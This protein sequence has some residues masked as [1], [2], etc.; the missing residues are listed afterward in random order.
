MSA[1]KDLMDAIKLHRQA[2]Q[3]LVTASNN[4]ARIIDIADRRRD[5]QLRRDWDRMGVK[6]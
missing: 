5:D 2:S 4:A 6:V 1:I 3:E